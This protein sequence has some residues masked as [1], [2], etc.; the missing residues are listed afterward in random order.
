[1]EKRPWNVSERLKPSI[2]KASHALGREFPGIN[3]LAVVV[4]P[5]DILILPS[6]ASASRMGSC[7]L[8][9]ISQNNLS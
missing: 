9:T 4:I 8:D 2:P 3:Y 1:M 6:L 7:N 5:S